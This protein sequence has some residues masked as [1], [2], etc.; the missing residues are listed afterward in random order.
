MKRFILSMPI[1]CLL[2]GCV[3]TPEEEPIVNR[4]DA[5]ENIDTVTADGPQSVLGGE[6]KA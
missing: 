2:A 3:P 4:S 1:L 6:A 5:Y